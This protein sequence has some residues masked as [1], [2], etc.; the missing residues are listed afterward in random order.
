M[1]SSLWS[2]EMWVTFS[3]LAVCLTVLYL[4]WRAERL[5]LRAR[6]QI[7]AAQMR[8]DRTEEFVTDP[9]AH[10]LA[11]TLSVDPIPLDLMLLAGKES[12]TWARESALKSMYELYD[13]VK[14]WNVVRAVWKPYPEVEQS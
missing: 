11:N 6:P 13:N 3:V 2:S 1:D 10:A 7:P 9:A 14:D 5:W 12:E 4:A 8:I